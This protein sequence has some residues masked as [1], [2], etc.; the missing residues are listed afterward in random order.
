VLQPFDNAAETMIDRNELEQVEVPDS[1]C[2]QQT[3]NEEEKC[4][5]VVPIG[6]VEV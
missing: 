3:T 4:S 1:I 2:P 5:A 6:N